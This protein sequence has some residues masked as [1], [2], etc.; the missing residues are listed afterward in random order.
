[1]DSALIENF[2]QPFR[3]LER[4]HDNSW[5]PRLCSQDGRALSSALDNLPVKP[6]RAHR[7]VHQAIALIEQP[8]AHAARLTPYVRKKLP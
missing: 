2:D 3:L 4:R 5:L 6:Y 7:I 1:L 8:V